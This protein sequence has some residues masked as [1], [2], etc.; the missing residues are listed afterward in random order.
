MTTPRIRSLVSLA[1]ALSFTM[2][3]GACA[4]GAPHFATDTSLSADDALRALRFDNTGREY[5]HVYLISEQ[6]EWLLGR[7][8]PGARS[9]LRIPAEA[10]SD[11]AGGMQLEVVIGEPVTF[12][13]KRASRM[14]ITTVQ[15]GSDL[16]AQRWTFSQ[17]PAMGQLT[18]LP[19]RSQ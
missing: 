1:A 16:F 18:S 17:I 4:T 6:R 19:A 11:D 10:T 7:V 3:L 8:E 2:T 13:A 5:V 9:T 12:G 14:A 15:P